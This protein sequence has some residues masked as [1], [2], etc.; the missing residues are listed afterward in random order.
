MRRLKCPQCEISRFYVKN[1]ANETCLVEVNETYEI[2]PVHPDFS[3]EN[4]NL[5][6]LYCL[7]CSWQ[8]SPKKLRK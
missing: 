2:V 3:L 4:F 6:W 8:G 1:A 5:D 7:G